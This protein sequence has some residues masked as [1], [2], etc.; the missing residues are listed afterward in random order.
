MD[1]S[2]WIIPAVSALGAFAGAWGAVKADIAHLKQRVH[3]VE[4]QMDTWIK[5]QIEQ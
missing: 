2:Q 5:A 3:R 1:W 4:T